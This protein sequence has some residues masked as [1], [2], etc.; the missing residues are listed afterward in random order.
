MAVA[1]NCPHLTALYLERAGRISDECITALAAGCPK[2]CTLDLGWCEFSPATACWMHRSHPCRAHPIGIPSPP[3]SRTSLGPIP[4]WIPYRLDPIPT[5][6]QIGD[7][8]LEALASGCPALH[9]INLAYCDAITDAGFGALCAGCEKIQSLDIG[10]CSRLTEKALGAVAL[11]CSRLLSLDLG[12]CKHL[13][14]DHSLGVL[15]KSCPALRSLNLR[16]CELI[17]DRAIADVQAQCVNV[18]VRR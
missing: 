11:N 13:V 10:G 1:A 2:L 18:Q 12:G 8:A 7:A 5:G 14:T 9:T 17:T 4:V 16:F 3:G 6:S 15:A